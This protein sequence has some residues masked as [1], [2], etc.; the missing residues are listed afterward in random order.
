MA[1]WRGV[2]VAERLLLLTT[3][4]VTPFLF[5][6]HSPPSF[7]GLRILSGRTYGLADFSDFVSALLGR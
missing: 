5:V 1:P 3:A 7:L 2:R 6:P 4:L